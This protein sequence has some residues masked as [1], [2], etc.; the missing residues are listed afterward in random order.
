MGKIS[1]VE[2]ATS[3]PLVVD[4]DGTLTPTDTLVESILSLLKKNPLNLFIISFWLFTGRAEF[5]RRIASK[6]DFSV[7]NLPWHEEFLTW[8]RVQHDNGRTLILAT[9]AHQSIAQDVACHIKLFSHVI[10]TE[11]GANLKGTAK[12]EE[13]QKYVGSRFS[14]AGDSAADLPIWRAAETAVL[15]SSSDAVRRE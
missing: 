1:L 9:A 14:Y 7:I 2:V 13:I 15:I 10:S 6:G 4:L 11:N 5:K 8:L 12:L 3:L